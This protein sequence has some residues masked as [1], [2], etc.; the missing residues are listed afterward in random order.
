MNNFVIFLKPL[1]TERRSWNKQTD[2]TRD[3]GRSSHSNANQ[4]APTVEKSLRSNMN[5]AASSSNDRNAAS[6]PSRPAASKRNH[7][8]GRRE[9]LAATGRGSNSRNQA[10]PSGSSPRQHMSGSPD[11]DDDD[12]Y[13]GS[14]SSTE[15]RPHDWFEEDAGEEYTS[16][17]NY[18][19]CEEEGAS[20]DEDQPGHIRINPEWFDIH[21][22]NDASPPQDR[23]LSSEQAKEYWMKKA[24][25][26]AT[27]AR[28]MAANKCTRNGNAQ[29]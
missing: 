25:V 2:K 23:F 18:D 10:R 5:Q 22:Q 7:A 1:L 26:N 4:E 19:S 17:Q 9:E 13:D 16:E 29:N 6:S 24:G 20:D 11:D 27:R 3:K 8:S 28:P 14:S 21:S 15:C 12:D